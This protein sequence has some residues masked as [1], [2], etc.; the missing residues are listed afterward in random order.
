MGSY[1][2]VTEQKQLG[3]IQDMLRARVQVVARKFFL[4]RELK[5]ESEEGQSSWR[6][7]VSMETAANHLESFSFR[8]S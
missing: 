4:Q 5:R 6:H 7:A 1:L 3:Q 2:H 8:A